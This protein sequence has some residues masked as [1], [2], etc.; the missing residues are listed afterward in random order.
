MGRWCTHYRDADQKDDSHLEWYAMAPHEVSS[1]CSELH[2]ISNLGIDFSKNFPCNIFRP[3]FTTYFGTTENMA[4]DK[5][6]LLYV[7][8][9]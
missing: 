3:W 2:T 5:E 7:K 8:A 9:P 4:T 1:H 6:R